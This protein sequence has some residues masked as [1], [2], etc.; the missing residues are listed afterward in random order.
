M[1]GRSDSLSH[2]TDF[3]VIVKELAKMEGVFVVEGVLEAVTSAADADVI[4]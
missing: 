3:A 2:I 4:E 1:L